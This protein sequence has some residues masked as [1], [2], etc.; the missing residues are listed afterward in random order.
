MVRVRREGRISS[1]K[2]KRRKQAYMMIVRNYTEICNDVDCSNFLVYKDMLSPNVHE[3]ESKDACKKVYTDKNATHK[4]EDVCGVTTLHPQKDM[5]IQNVVGC[6][7]VSSRYG[8]QHATFER[9]YGQISLTKIKYPENKNDV[10]QLTMPILDHA[11]THT[12]QDE[13]NVSLPCID[14]KQ[15]C[16]GDQERNVA[17]M[18][19]QAKGADALKLA[20]AKQNTFVN[21]QPRDAERE[22][23]LA[24]AL[25]C[26]HDSKTSMYVKRTLGASCPDEN[27]TKDNAAGDIVRDQGASTLVPEPLVSNNSAVVKEV[28][29]DVK[30]T[31]SASRPD[32]DT[33]WTTFQAMIFRSSR[34]LTS[35]R[36]QEPQGLPALRKQLQMSKT[37]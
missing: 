7:R 35:S 31:P 37:N 36:S 23:A 30:G 10:A 16:A 28:V 14:C 20:Q 26:G 33:M 13:K 15:V 8:D 32:E 5:Y 2:L 22:S 19:V 24:Q 25:A 21:K 12:E 17:N 29:K 3:N 1:S 6:D 34:G 11:C 4:S 27:I 18:L 9:G